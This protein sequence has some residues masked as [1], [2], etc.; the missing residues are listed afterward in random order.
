LIRDSWY[1]G[2]LVFFFEHAFND[3]IQYLALIDVA[4][5]NTTTSYKKTIP[6]VELRG[7][8]THTY[9]V[10]RFEDIVASVGLVR[11]SVTNAKEFKVISHHIFKE[12]LDK[13]AGVLSRL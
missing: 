2:S 1:I 13:N 6:L 7:E 12:N 4:K 11:S 3:Q 9:A 5:R 10:C 8:N